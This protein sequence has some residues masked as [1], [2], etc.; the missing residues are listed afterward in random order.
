[1]M[2]SR[3]VRGMRSVVVSVGAAPAGADK[4]LAATF[5]EREGFV[6]LAIQDSAPENTNGMTRSE[7]TLVIEPGEY[8]TTQ[9]DATKDFAQGEGVYWDSANKRFT[10]DAAG[11]R[12]MGMVTVAKDAGGCVWFYLAPQIPAAF[13]RAAAQADSTANDVAGLAADFNAML[14]KLRDAGL[15]AP[16]A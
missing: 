6:G 9:I 15:M 13:R 14:D 7:V 11:N 3:M 10:T 1:M 2:A 12:W 4:I 8:E 5:V 16:N